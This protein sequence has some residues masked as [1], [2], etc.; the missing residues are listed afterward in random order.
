MYF[1]QITD[2]FGERTAAEGKGFAI[3]IKFVLIG[4]IYWLLSK[5]DEIQLSCRST[6]GATP[7]P[8]RACA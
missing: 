4:C 6:A 1:G 2:I 8:L 3:M 5:R 7:A